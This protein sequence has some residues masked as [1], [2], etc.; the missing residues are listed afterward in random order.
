MHISNV[1]KLE[2]LVVRVSLKKDTMTYMKAVVALRG[3]N[4]EGISTARKNLY[5]HIKDAPQQMLQP[6]A[7]ILRRP[8]ENPR[9]LEVYEADPNM[10]ASSSSVLEI[11]RHVKGKN[12][13]KLLDKRLVDLHDIFPEDLAM[14]DNGTAGLNEEEKAGMIGS[15][16]AAIELRI[17]RELM[18]IYDTRAFRMRLSLREWISSYR[19]PAEFEKI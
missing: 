4:P 8:P 14:R 9:L 18:K 11:M 16:A 1:I 2:T 6:Y 10:V 3:D 7:A 13:F 17:E 15:I 12:T 19:Q 5:I